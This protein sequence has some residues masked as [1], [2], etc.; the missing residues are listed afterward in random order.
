MSD[1]LGKQNLKLIKFEHD[2]EKRKCSLID[3]DQNKARENDYVIY[4][5]YSPFML[6]SEDSL[7]ELNSK[8]AIKV[9]ILNFRPNFFVQNCEPF[10]E[11][12]SYYVLINNR[13]MDI[14]L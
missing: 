14:V 8:L 13:I 10:A 5:D 9:P 11:V 12:F 4:Q 7:I 6:I 3:E 2:L 1:F